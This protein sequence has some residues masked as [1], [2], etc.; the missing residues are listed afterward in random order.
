[1]KPYSYQVKQETEKPATTNAWVAQPKIAA[2]VADALSSLTTSV[3]V[4][5]STVAIASLPAVK[6]N[7]PASDVVLI[8]TSVTGG[9]LLLKSLLMAKPLL[10][11]LE[12]LTERDLNRDGHVGEP[13]E[14]PR[15][16][17]G[18]QEGKEAHDNA[19][20]LWHYTYQQLK[21]ASEDGRTLKGKP[22]ARR[23]AVANVPT[24]TET[25]W[26][27]VIDL[28]VAGGLLK[29]RDANE[30]SAK[31]YRQGINMIEDGMRTM[32]FIRLNENWLHK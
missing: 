7:W 23:T 19:L 26:T 29:N 21:W 13:E 15:V 24:I 31:H 3:T 27:D 28:W 16:L 8:A 10:F 22:W 9:V 1:V 25:N 20:K 32:G 5:V 18:V 12:V 2:V 17:P 6:G 4:F 14:A 30:V 11:W